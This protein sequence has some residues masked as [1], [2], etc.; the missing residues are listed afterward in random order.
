MFPTMISSIILG[1]SIAAPIGPINIEIVKRGL[2]YGFWPAFLVG[3]G[4]MSSDLLLMAAMF[5]GLSQVLTMVWV[6]ITLMGLGC[7]IL[8]HSGWVNL[9]ASV[10]PNE[11][12]E[13]VH[14]QSVQVRRR[15]YITGLTIAG[16]N[17]MNLLFWI[18]IYGSVLSSSFQQDNQLQA[19]LTSSLV[20]VGI[21]LWNLNLALTVHFSRILM[22]QAVMR[23]IC[24][25][26]SLVLIGFG[27]YFGYQCAV[28]VFQ[29]I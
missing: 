1:L 12:K 17:P 7:F 21:G 16:T 24:I 14:R 10:V 4:G 3:L 2:L 23:S 13:S 6:K 26:A 22:N 8:I 27:I 29:I 18:S 28:L 9:F 5:F 11:A 15:S 25:I 20:F 19:F